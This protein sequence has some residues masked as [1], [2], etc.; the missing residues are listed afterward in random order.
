MRSADMLLA[1]QARGDADAAEVAAIARTLSTVRSPSDAALD[2]GEAL[3]ALFLVKSLGAEFDHAL[4]QIAA[5]LRDA[6]RLLTDDDASALLLRA[7]LLCSQLF[8][9]GSGRTWPIEYRIPYEIA[10]ALR[11]ACEPDAAT[12]FPLLVRDVRALCG[13]VRIE[14]TEIEAVLARHGGTPS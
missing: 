7:D 10:N 11:R 12:L 5:I 2:V 3:L 13:D 14:T 8:A 4:S 1:E 6:R 9:K